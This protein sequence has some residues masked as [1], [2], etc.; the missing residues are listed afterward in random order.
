MLVAAAFSTL[1]VT[2]TCAQRQ[3]SPHHPVAVAVIESHSTFMT[4]LRTRTGA[5]VHFMLDSGGG[6]PFIFADAAKRLAPSGT[7]VLSCDA[8]LPFPVRP[9]IAPTSMRRGDPIIGSTMDGLLGGTWLDGHTW[10]WNYPRGTLQLRA[11][12]DDPAVSRS[13]VVSLGFQEQGGRHTTG[14][15]RIA[16]AIDG[17]SYQFLLD[18][19]AHTRVTRSAQIRGGFPTAPFAANFIEASIAARWHR[20]HPSWPYLARAEIGSAADMIRVRSVI[21]G[22]YT[23]GPTWFTI[24]PDASY[25]TFMSKYMDRPVVGSIG[26][27]TLRHFRLTVDYPNERAYFEMSRARGSSSAASVAIAGRMPIKRGFAPMIAPLAAG[28]RIIATL[29]SESPT[30]I[31]APR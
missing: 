18:T 1:A 13:H 27:A 19:G 25:S 16:A 22:G 20:A 7:L 24:R 30:P 6:G 2:S 15:A 5:R 9:L 8:A 28:P 3:P 23:V 14:F 21:I 26:G 17:T 29:L 31:I 10:T 11:A 4:D 12:G